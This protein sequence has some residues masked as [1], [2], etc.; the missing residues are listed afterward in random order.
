MSDKEQHILQWIREVSKVR[1][2]LNGFAIC[3]FAS[4]AKF[5]IIECSAAEIQPIEGYQVIIFIIEDHFDLNMVQYW[6]DYHNSKHPTWKFFEDCGTYDTFINDIQTNN[7]KY[8][9]ILAQPTEKLRK[10]RENLAKTSYYSLWDKEYLKEI[11][12]NDYD[13]I[14]RDSNPLKSSVL[15]S[16]KEKTDGNEPKSR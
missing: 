15:T 6:V 4:K 12:E 1:P 10:F 14:E 9:L 2:E 7:G 3:P 13:I 16:N 5:K 8:N 11:L